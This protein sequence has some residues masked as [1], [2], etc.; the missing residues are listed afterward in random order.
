MVA[1]RPMWYWRGTWE[2]NI[3]IG[4]QK[5]ERDTGPGLSIWNPKAYS[6]WQTFSNQVTVPNS[7]TPYGQA[8][9]RHSIQ[10][11]PA[12]DPYWHCP[13]VIRAGRPISSGKNLVDTVL[14][15]CLRNLISWMLTDSKAFCVVISCLFHE[16]VFCLFVCLC[17]TMPCACGGQKWASD[18]LIL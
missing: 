9:G 10:S 12:A 5:E 2:L 8:Y 1:Y 7:A 11:S 14:E 4:S 17:T 16:C 6:Q 15:K 3:W 13:Q 18:P